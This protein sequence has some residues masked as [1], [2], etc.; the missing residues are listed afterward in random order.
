MCCAVCCVATDV[1]VFA[2]NERTG[3]RLRFRLRSCN[4]K[5]PVKMNAM[6]L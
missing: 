4:L 2:V 3:F 6:V 5:S 1:Q